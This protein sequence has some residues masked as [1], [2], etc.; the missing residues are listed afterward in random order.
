MA[1]TPIKPRR[2]RSASNQFAPK[3]VHERAKN[4]KTP[5][6][7]IGHGVKIYASICTNPHRP[8]RGQ[9][10]GDEN[11]ADGARTRNHRIDSPVSGECLRRCSVDRKTRICAT[12]AAVAELGGCS[13]VSGFGGD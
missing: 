10:K 5:S 12:A 3:G 1:V 9:G 4:N 2:K 8:E 7:L 13:R 11:E 6:P